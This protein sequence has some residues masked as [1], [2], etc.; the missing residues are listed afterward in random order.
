MTVNTEV[1]SQK[2][3]P[4]HGLP[5]LQ[6]PDPLL[7]SVLLRT[8]TVWFAPT[9]AAAGMNVNG[10]AAPHPPET[11]RLSLRT[12]VTVTAVVPRLASVTTTFTFW[13]HTTFVLRCGEVTL[14]ESWPSVVP[15][16]WVVTGVGE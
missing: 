16:G 11:T 14:A 15:A 13:V 2:L 5:A 7:N 9:S 10:W 8:V 3:E 6:Q 1:N 12:P 4:L